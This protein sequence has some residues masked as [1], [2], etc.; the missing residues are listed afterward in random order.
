M[1]IMLGI[2]AAGTIFMVVFLYGL[3]RDGQRCRH[4]VVVRMLGTH[5][6]TC[7]PEG[8]PSAQDDA[9]GTPGTF[10]RVVT[11]RANS[12]AGSRRMSGG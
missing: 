5:W 4:A 8:E 9:R 6:E 1:A 12:A 2:S 3:Y 11:I 7:P 10:P